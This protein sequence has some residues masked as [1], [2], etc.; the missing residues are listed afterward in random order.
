MR[1]CAGVHLKTNIQ[2]NFVRYCISHLCHMFSILWYSNLKSKLNDIEKLK[3]NP[4]PSL[5]ITPTTPLAEQCPQT[6]VVKTAHSYELGSHMQSKAS[7]YCAIIWLTHRKSVSICKVV[8]CFQSAVV[9]T[10]CFSSPL[11]E[12]VHLSMS[13]LYCFLQSEAGNRY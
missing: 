6:E 2:S 13:L 7:K 5:L 10:R 1:M 11:F 9:Q 4:L 8:L 12:K 3:R